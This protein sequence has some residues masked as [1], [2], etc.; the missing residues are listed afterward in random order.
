MPRMSQLQFLWEG[1]LSQTLG[2][3]NFR[4]RLNITINEEFR[5]PNFT[6]GMVSGTSDRWRTVGPLL[7]AD[8]IK[9]PLRQID[10]AKALPNAFDV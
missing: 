4:L 2:H 1:A 6:R 7:Q 5:L 8:D 10:Y 3:D 9:K